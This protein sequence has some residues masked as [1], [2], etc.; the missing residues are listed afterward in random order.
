M[1]LRTTNRFDKAF[2]PKAPKARTIPAQGNAL[3]NAPRDDPALKGRPMHTADC[4]A[5]TGLNET[6]NTVPGALPQAGMERAVG[7]ADDPLTDRKGPLAL[8]TMR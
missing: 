5:P 3:G 7:P 4:P 1:T 8:L 6:G 2:D